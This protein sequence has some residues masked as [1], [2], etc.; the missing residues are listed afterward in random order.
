V[1][2]LR[3][4]GANYTL[5]FNRDVSNCSVTA[6]TTAAPAPL[7]VSTGSGGT[8]NQVTITG[9]NASFHAQVMCA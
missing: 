6:N 5:T 2:T 4:A 7:S 3:G 1:L 9:A 8:A